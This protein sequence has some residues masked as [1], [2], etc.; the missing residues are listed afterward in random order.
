MYMWY[1]QL[2]HETKR[3]AVWRVWIVYLIKGKR[4]GHPR[5]DHEG[6]EGE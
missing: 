1:G 4:K 5:T 2:E 3:N 6:P